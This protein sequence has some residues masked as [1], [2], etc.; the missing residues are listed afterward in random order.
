M[1][2]LHSRDR[3]CA[4]QPENEGQILEHDLLGPAV[5]WWNAG[6]EDDAWLG[7]DVASA[8]DVNGDGYSD[9]L[10]AAPGYDTALADAG[11]PVLRVNL[12]WY[13]EEGLDALVSA[14]R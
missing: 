1:D 13:V 4:I 14:L 10:V 6:D 2:V 7:Y 11:R 12:G 9:V 3:R 8:G 5:D